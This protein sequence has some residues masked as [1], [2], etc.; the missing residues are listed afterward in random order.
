MEGSF[1]RW[2]KGPV[3]GVRTPATANPGPA[4]II[5]VSGPAGDTG[6]GLPA[7]QAVREGI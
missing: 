4:T 5:Y 6:I 3:P 1:V 7:G 2:Q